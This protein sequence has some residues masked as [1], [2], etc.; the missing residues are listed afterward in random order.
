MAYPTS[1]HKKGNE[2]VKEQKR[3]RRGE[4]HYFGDDSDLTSEERELLAT[5]SSHELA[6]LPEA[7]FFES[8]KDGEITSYI[9]N[10]N[11]HG[12]EDVIK[13]PNGHDYDIDY[14]SKPVYSFKYGVEDHQTGDMKS[15]REERDGDR[16]VGEYSLVEPDGT[17][18]T[19]KYTADSK[20]GFNA[21]VHTHH[22]LGDIHAQVE[23]S[24]VDY[25]IE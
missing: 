10:T 8:A 18:R 23:T 21:V 9:E 17:I 5:L 13:Y 19:V 15:V 3:Q 24:Q 1:E 12:P 2:K 25:D 22:G 11:H 4:H 7:N 14:H 16:V 20:N 6:G